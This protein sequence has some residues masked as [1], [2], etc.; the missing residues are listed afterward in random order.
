M[1]R[2]ETM[3]DTFSFM[4]PVSNV[5]IRKSGDG[6]SSASARFKIDIEASNEFRDK[7]NEVVL[8]KAMEE[9]ADGFLSEGVISWDHMHKDEDH[10]S[11]R[12]IIGEP[13]DVQF[14]SG[15]KS[16][17]VKAQ[18][19]EKNSVARDLVDNLES[20][21]TRF[22]ASVGGKKLAKS[23]TGIVQRVLW[24]EVA[25][26][27]KPVNAATLGS[28]R[29]TPM[30]ALAKALV[31]G[32]GVNPAHFTSGRAMTLES[33]M[34]AEP[35]AVDENGNRDYTKPRSD[36][37]RQIDWQMDEAIREYAQSV[38]KKGFK[39]ALRFVKANPEFTDDQLVE[40]LVS[41]KISE[42]S[43]EVIVA[44]LKSNMHKALHVLIQ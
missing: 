44:Y 22:G 26:T 19:Y 27:Y 38:Y 9:A 30:E 10:S 23:F 43:A 4:L 14:P 7:D 20:G 34:G 41:K 13:L 1:D 15:N 21:S 12:F 5:T 40:H 36:L 32:S 33:L 17:L 18:L 2:K 11:P 8:R 31:A 16:T 24:D 37:A 42:S 6:G 39:I 29:Q 3:G 35:A 25:V 28:V